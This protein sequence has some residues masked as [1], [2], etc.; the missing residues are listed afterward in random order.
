MPIFSVRDKEW[1]VG[2]GVLLFQSPIPCLG[3]QKSEVRSQ[4]SGVR[5]QESEVRIQNGL[6]PTLPPLPTSHAP[7][8][9]PTP[10]T[11][12]YPQFP[13]NHKVIR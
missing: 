13:K 6:L 5:S 9:S 11:T 3:S 4:E 7:H 1:E 10:H 8:T 2:M 12:A